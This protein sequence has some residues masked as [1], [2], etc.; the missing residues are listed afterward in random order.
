MGFGWDGGE[1]GVKGMVVTKVDPN[2]PEVVTGV[3]V[4]DTQSFVGLIFNN[5]ECTVERI[6]GL[7]VTMCQGC[8]WG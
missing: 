4:A 2:G 3:G 5:A 1:I 8:L 7:A 6:V